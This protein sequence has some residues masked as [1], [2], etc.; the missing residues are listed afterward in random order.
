MLGNAIYFL[1]I[2][3]LACCIYNVLPPEGLYPFK[4]QSKLVANQGFANIFANMFDN[5]FTWFGKPF[6]KEL[7]N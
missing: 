7:G 5:L 6:P 2:I 4:V 3:L 1:F